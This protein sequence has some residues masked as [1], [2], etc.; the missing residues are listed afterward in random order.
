MTSLIPNTYSFYLKFTKILLGKKSMDLKYL[1][2]ISIN[3]NLDLQI[4]LLTV[5]GLWKWLR[6]RVW[7]RQIPCKGYKNNSTVLISHI[8]AVYLTCTN[9]SNKILKPN[10]FVKPGQIWTHVAYLVYLTIPSQ[11]QNLKQLKS[12]RN[13]ILNWRCFSILIQWCLLKILV[14]IMNVWT[15]KCQIE[16]QTLKVQAQLW[17][18]TIRLL[19]GNSLCSLWPLTL[20]TTSLWQWTRVYRTRKRK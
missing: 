20:I 4:W 2:L 19:E 12:L 18:R 13:T 14:S 15:A 16:V 10:P 9:N 1:L 7:K 5:K 6:K 11:W 17:L 3:P 8:K